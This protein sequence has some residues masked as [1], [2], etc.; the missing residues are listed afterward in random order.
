MVEIIT[1]SDLHKAGKLRFIDKPNLCMTH[2]QN[3][4][5]VVN[6]QR[7]KAVRTDQRN[8][9]KDSRQRHGLESEREKIV[10]GK[11]EVHNSCNM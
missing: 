11:K 2:F 4:F 7:K 6:W 9:V 8:C 1:L 5:V 3:H 10:M